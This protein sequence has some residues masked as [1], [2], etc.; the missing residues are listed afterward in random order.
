M[1]REKSHPSFTAKGGKELIAL[2]HLSRHC[3]GPGRSLPRGGGGRR[4][5]HKATPFAPAPRVLMHECGCVARTSNLGR[6]Y[7]R[8]ALTR[9]P[10]GTQSPPAPLAAGCPFGIIPLGPGGAPCPKRRIVCSCKGINSWCSHAATA[11]VSIN[12]FL[13]CQC[14]DV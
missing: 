10:R 14:I 12:C 7:Y 13:L 5:K 2:C 1:T 9:V 11:D 8:P 6:P 3:D 4:V